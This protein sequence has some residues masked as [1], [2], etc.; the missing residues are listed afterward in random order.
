MINK[1]IWFIWTSI[2]SYVS[3]RCTGQ[4][5]DKLFDEL[6]TKWAANTKT[7]IDDNLVEEWKRKL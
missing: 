6:L 3:K 5:M 2:I 1:I 4:F 7:K